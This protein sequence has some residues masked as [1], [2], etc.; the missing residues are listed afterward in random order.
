MSLLSPLRY[1]HR[2]A[3]E[4]VSEGDR[5]IDATV[6]NGKDTLFLCETVGPAGFVYGF[7][8]QSIALEQAERLLEENLG[9]GAVEVRYR[10]KSHG[11]VRSRLQRDVKQLGDELHKLTD[12]TRVLLWQ[13]S[14]A[15]MLEFIPRYEHGQ[16]AAIMFNL[17][18]L[19]GGDH[20]LTTL[21]SST[22]PALE[23]SLQ[24]LKVNGL[25]SI[26]VYPGHPEGRVEAEEVNQWA[27]ALPQRS[28][29]VRLYQSMNQV[30]HPPYHIAIV[31]NKHTYKE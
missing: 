7:D 20:G 28:Y 31:K 2:L 24:L 10:A 11:Q 21:P 9:T 30:N 12:E 16:I 6:G 18:Y 17:G 14:H 3:S 1:A 5:V 25:L 29:Q 8:I 27:R 26:M 23:A 13:Q 19:P 4:F 15:D 22:I